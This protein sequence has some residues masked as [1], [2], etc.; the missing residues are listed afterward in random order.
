MKATTTTGTIAGEN[1]GNPT[2]TA[3]NVEHGPPE[4]PGGSASA[5]TGHS[6]SDSSPKS[7]AEAL[8]IS[9]HRDLIRRVRVIAACRGT[10]VSRIVTSLLAEAV[11]REL[12]AV[13]AEL[14]GD[15]SATKGGD[16]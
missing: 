12:P 1:A 10:S 13:L 7:V 8:T 16:P 3:D 9:L 4:T 5:T 2:G 14:Q 15:A 11:Q 6:S